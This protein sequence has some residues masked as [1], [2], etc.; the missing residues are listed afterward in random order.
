MTLKHTFKRNFKEAGFTLVE[1]VISMSIALFMIGGIVYS[2]IVAA[3]RAEWTANSLAAQSA[4]LQV[5][6]RTRSAPWLPR[7][8]VD[9]V[10][11][12]NSAFEPSLT[13]TLGMGVDATI[14]TEIIDQTVIPPLKKISVSCSW[15][16]RGKTFTNTIVTYRAPDQ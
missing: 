10:T 1:V 15:G 12:A 3:Y 2:Y 16:L 6:E 8:G 11:T 9:L 13:R 14:T 7:G 4:V 5:I